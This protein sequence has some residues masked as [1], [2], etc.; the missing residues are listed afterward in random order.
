[1]RK[2]THVT[3]LAFFAAGLFLFTGMAAAGEKKLMHCFAFTPVESATPAQWKA[4]Y[5]ATDQLPKKVPGIS[6]VWYGKLRRNLDTRKYGVCMEM[7]NEDTLKVYTDHPFHKQWVD[8]Y[9]KVREEGTTTFDIL[10]Q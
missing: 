7:A 1:M 4:F 2:L 10:G 5:D 8:V 9:S 6:H 3:R